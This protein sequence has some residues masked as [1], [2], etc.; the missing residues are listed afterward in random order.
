MPNKELRDRLVASVITPSRA[1][2]AMHCTP[3]SIRTIIIRAGGSKL[4]RGMCAKKALTLLCK[5]A[6]ELAAERKSQQ[7]GYAIDRASLHEWAQLNCKH[8]RR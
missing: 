7:R 3:M 4:L 6:S 1:E 8:D 2:L 5:A